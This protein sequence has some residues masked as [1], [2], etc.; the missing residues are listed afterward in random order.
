M[1]HTCMVRCFVTLSQNDN[2]DVAN[3]DVGESHLD[4]PMV[5]CTIKVIEYFIPVE[6]L[7][8]CV[9]KIKVKIIRLIVVCVK[10]INE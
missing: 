10:N 9:I 1:G 3:L 4:T 8:V 6:M 5:Q 2:G 7:T